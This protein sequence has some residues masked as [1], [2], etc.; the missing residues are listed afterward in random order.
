[1][2]EAVKT[3]LLVTYGGGHAHMIGPLVH[4]LKADARCE[5]GEVDI[6]VLALPAAISILERYQVEFFTLA[7]YLDPDMDSDAVAWGKTL[8]NE[9]HS[10]SSGIN[11]RESIAYLGLCYKDL[12][13]RHGADRAEALLREEGRR[14]FFPLTIMERICDDLT[15][16]FVIT[17]NSPRSE[18]AAIAIANQRGIDS[19]IMTDLFTGLGGYLLQAKHIS[20]LNPVARDMFQQDGLVDPSISEFHFTGNPAFDC[21]PAMRGDA[22]PDWLQRQF[23]AARGDTAVLL[24]DTP[25]YW[26]PVNGCS[27]FRSDEEILGEL[28]AVFQAATD[29]RAVLLV[30]PH[31]SQARDLYV[32]WAEKHDNCFLAIE[33]DLHDLLRNISLLLVRTSTVGLEAAYLGTRV[34]QLDCDY[35][36]DLPLAKMG[37]SWGVNSFDDLTNEMSK[38]LTDDLKFESISR[39][40]RAMLPFEPAAD[41]IAGIVLNRLF[42]HDSLDDG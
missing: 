36:T 29:N 35:H 8:A 21:L 13:L 30:R 39:Q 7:N 11:L 19:L 20:F 27:H 3:I 34:L 37:I 31:P 22:E 25:A 9:H 6:R 28:D 16:D 26:D 18:A 15:P 2:S 10:T 40:T 17:T 32:R 12:V 14:A 42:L 38:A 23:P 1:M 33:N 4:A 5:N 41:K 24:A